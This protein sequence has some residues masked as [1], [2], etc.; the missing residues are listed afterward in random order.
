MITLDTS[1]LLAYINRSDP[2]NA[3]V[4]PALEGDTGPRIVPVSILA[5]ITYLVERHGG[6]R[7]LRTFLHDLR[8]REFDLD[9]GDRDLA[10]IDALVD[11]YADLPLGFADAAV[12]ACAER[13]GG[14]VLT[15]DRRHFT[16]LARGERT[17]TLVPEVV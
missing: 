10:R 5:E 14:R 8:E 6:T 11:R 7:L 1:G 16:V 3:L 13:H 9:C 17:L 4:A 12:A 15:L 2:Y